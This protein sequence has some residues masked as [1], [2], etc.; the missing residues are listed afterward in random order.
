MRGFLPS[1]QIRDEDMRSGFIESILYT[2]ADMQRL[3]GPWDTLSKLVTQ[4]KPTEDM[5]LDELETVSA[6]G[7]PSYQN[8][9]RQINDLRET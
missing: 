6:A 4:F 8:F 1:R 7:H 3:A 2:A 5:D 9:I